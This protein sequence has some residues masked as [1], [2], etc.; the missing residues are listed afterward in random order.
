M[1]TTPINVKEYS[2]AGEYIPYAKVVKQVD[3]ILPDRLG[4]EK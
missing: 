4:D 3:V 2:T 1:L